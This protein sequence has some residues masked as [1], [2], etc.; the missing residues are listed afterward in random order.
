MWPAKGC[1]HINAHPTDI[2]T[3]PANTDAHSTNIN[4]KPYSRH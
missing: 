1:F 4:P 3:H 2:D